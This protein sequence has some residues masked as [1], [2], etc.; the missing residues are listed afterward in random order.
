MHDFIKKKNININFFSCLNIRTTK[1][2]R[3]C[4]RRNTIKEK[5][6]NWTHYSEWK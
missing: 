1:L 4:A 6:G 3:D 5:I 2:E